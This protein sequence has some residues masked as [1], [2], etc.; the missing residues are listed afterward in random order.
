MS[1]PDS[2]AV[3]R[4]GIP[5]VVWCRGSSASPLCFDIIA[6]CPTHLSFNHQWSSFSGRC[7]PTVEHSAAERHVCIVN[8]CFR[9]TFEDPSLQSFFPWIS[10]SACAVTIFNFFTYLLTYLMCSPYLSGWRS[11]SIVQVFADWPHLCLWE[12]NSFKSTQ[13]STHNHSHANHACYWWH[14]LP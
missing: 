9:E 2:S 7:C 14:T 13:Y 11:A 5:S 12:S 8:I 6:C 3:P 1:T 4:W 10:S